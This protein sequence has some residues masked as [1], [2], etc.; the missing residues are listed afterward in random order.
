MSERCVSGDVNY[1]NLVILELTMKKCYCR[2]DLIPDL[3]VFCQ[4]TSLVDSQVYAKS[5]IIIHDKVSYRCILHIVLHMIAFIHLL[6]L[7]SSCTYF[8]PF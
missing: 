7:L 2:D 8:G 5:F 6:G 4:C 1:N 3:L